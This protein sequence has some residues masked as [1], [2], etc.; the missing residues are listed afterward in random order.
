MRDGDEVGVQ[1]P[2]E[3][4][5]PEL[6]LVVISTLNAAFS[7]QGAVQRARTRI[8][9]KRCMGRGLGIGGNVG[10]FGISNA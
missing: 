1:T 7:E 4:D 3:N 6:A 2:A 8:R 9:M 5:P 10:S